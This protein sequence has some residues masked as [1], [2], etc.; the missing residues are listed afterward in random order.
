MNFAMKEWEPSDWRKE[1]TAAR[2]PLAVFVHTP[3]CG[4][5]KAT[6]RMLEV[7]EAMMPELPLAAANLNVMPDLAQ[8]FRIESIPCLLFKRPDGNI[9]K[10]YRFGSVTEVAQWLKQFDRTGRD[11]RS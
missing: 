9:E 2:G 4:T 6:R 3:L 11:K 7:V 1:W 8:T 5:C 10:R